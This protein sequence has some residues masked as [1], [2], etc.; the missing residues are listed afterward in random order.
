MT[1]KRTLWLIIFVTLLK[2]VSNLFLAWGMKHFP[3]TVSLD[4]LF[5]LTA[6][7]DPLVIVGILMQILW[8]ITR[9]S[10]LSV[11][12][13]SF[14]LPVTAAGYGI[15]TVLGRFILHE[16]VSLSRWAGAILISLGT[17]IAASSREKTT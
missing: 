5:Y 12:D 15:T 16:Q 17:A 6:M 1:N 2:P 4:P 3:A 7:L 10:L 9:M 13:L 11:A 8:L 14:V